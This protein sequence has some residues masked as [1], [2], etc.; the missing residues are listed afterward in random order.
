MFLHTLFFVGDEWDA[1]VELSLPLIIDS[2]TLWDLFGVD[3]PDFSLLSVSLSVV[4][5]TDFDFGFFKKFIKFITKKNTAMLCITLYLTN[6]KWSKNE[7]VF[8]FTC[9]I[10]SR[11]RV[12]FDFASWRHEGIDII[13]SM[14]SVMIGAGPLPPP[15]PDFV[16]DLWA[17]AINALISSFDGLDMK[18][19]QSC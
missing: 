8:F 4:S 9:L 1:S 16:T 2:V 19:I 3:F 5:S 15:S 18:N 7:I 11:T 14:R 13:L 6:I 12:T 17:W 10:H